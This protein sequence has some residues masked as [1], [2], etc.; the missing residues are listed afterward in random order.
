MLF[1]FVVVM[2]ACFNMSE[3]YIQR[4]N[5][6]KITLQ[7]VSTIDEVE[8]EAQ[9]LMSTGRL[10]FK[11]KP[12]IGLPKFLRLHIMV[13]FDAILSTGSKETYTLDFLPIGATDPL[14]MSRLISGKS[15]QGEV[16]IQKS[17]RTSMSTEGENFANMLIS[18][19]E[20]SLNLYF[21]NCWH[22]AFHCSQREAECRGIRAE[23]DI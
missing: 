2:I 9:S 6:P 19:F 16:R 23:T 7:R 11:F 1:L 14:I 4:M 13:A 17:D 8:S 3:G 20:P 18:G 21:N 12:L 10:Y 5:K 22:F 15:S